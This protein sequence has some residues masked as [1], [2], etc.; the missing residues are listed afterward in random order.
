MMRYC[1]LYQ[2]VGTKPDPNYKYSPNDCFSGLY[3]NVMSQKEIE[4]LVLKSYPT[5]YEASQKFTPNQVYQYYN[6]LRD[7]EFVFSMEEGQR[8]VGLNMNPAKLI[9]CYIFN[10][11]VQANSRLVNLILLNAIRYLYETNFHLIVSAF[12]KL[13]DYDT[14]I[15][16]FN[17]F[18]LAHS[19]TRESHHS[20]HCLLQSSIDVKRYYSDKDFVNLILKAPAR[21][22]SSVINDGERPYIAN[23]LLRSL[24]YVPAGTTG[25]AAFTRQEMT[26][27]KNELLAIWDSNDLKALFY[28]YGSKIVG[29]KVPD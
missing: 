29:A 9:D 19:L 8:M 24:T 12:L 22:K 25:P 5:N 26:D 18:L 23:Y 13:C 1:T 16:T 6:L 3:G 21:I 20:V 4:V 7:C 17:R 27:L 10:I 28:L 14:D 2:G 15:S 11:K